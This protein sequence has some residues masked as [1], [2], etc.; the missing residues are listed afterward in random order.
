MSSLE[1]LNLA[2]LLAERAGEFVLASAR[3]RASLPAMAANAE[4]V[5]VAGST[6]RVVYLTDYS[7]DDKLGDG[8]FL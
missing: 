5:A 1:A 6:L 8:S 7:S 4:D 2:L 3:W